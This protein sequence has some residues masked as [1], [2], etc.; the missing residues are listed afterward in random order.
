MGFIKGDITCATSKLLLIILI[1]SFL[2]LLLFMWGWRR[3]DLI[4]YHD[5]GELPFVRSVAD[6]PVGVVDEL[7]SARWKKECLFFNCF[8]I[9][10]CRYGN[11]N[12]ESIKVYVYSTLEVLTNLSHSL[13]SDWSQSLLSEPSDEY[14]ELIETIK[15]SR[16]YEPHPQEACVF[17][18]PMDTLN[19]RLINNGLITLLFN[20]L[21]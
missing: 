5:N 1:T 16:Y 8:D 21:K 2:F 14:L 4:S 3:N 10:M 11:E 6:Y 17:V 7:T 9:N 12:E 13:Q 19:G 18:S 15:A 20:N